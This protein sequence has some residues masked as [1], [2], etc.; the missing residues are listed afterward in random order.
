MLQI[1]YGTGK[2]KTTAAVGAAVRAAGAGWHVCF[3]QFFKNGDSAEVAILRRLGIDCRFPD[4][5]FTLGERIVGT[6]RTELVESYRRLLRTTLD[7]PRLPRLIVLD[8]A[9]DAFALALL[10][11]DELLAFLD[12]YPDTEVILTGHTPVPVLMERADYRTQMHAERHPYD[13]G[14]AARKGIEW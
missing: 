10:D 5:P 3:A 14:V 6:V 7:T 4:R 12:R 11:P 9:L 1:Y 8:E 13:H 2:G